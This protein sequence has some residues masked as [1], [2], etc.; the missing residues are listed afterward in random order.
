[1]R[2][3]DPDAYQIE[4]VQYFKSSSLMSRNQE[5]ER[6]DIREVYPDAYQIEN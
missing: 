6:K 2:E 3:D 5:G 4:N 1:M